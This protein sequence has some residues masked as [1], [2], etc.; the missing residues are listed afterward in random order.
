MC[1]QLFKK[2]ECFFQDLLKEKVGCFILPDTLMPGLNYTE[3]YY[4]L[5]EEAGQ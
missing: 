5:S 2:L 4:E 3:S 1:M